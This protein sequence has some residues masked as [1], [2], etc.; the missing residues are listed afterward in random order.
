MNPQKFIQYLGA[1]KAQLSKSKFDGEA[2]L[3]LR[4]VI[5]DIIDKY[6]ELHLKLKKSIELEG[7]KGKSGMTIKRLPRLFIIKEF[8]KETPNSKPKEIITKIPLEDFN[9]VLTILKLIPKNKEIRI[10]DFSEKYC[11]EFGLVEFFNGNEFQYE[12]LFGSRKTYLPKI[13]YPLKICWDFGFI[14]YDKR[15]VIIRLKEKMVIQTEFE[16]TVVKSTDVV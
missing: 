1:K 13:Y 9:K 5:D 7:W 3:I 11:N 14:S 16:D 8:R 15:G 6:N 2:K 4:D 12:K 10:R